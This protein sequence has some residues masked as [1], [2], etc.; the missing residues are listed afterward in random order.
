MGIVPTEDNLEHSCRATSA[1]LITIVNRGVAG[2]GHQ[3][4]KKEPTASLTES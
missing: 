1:L 2:K 3:A 4:D